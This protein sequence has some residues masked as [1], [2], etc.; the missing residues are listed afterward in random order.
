MST[1]TVYL[2][3]GANRGIGYGLVASLAARPNTI[4]FA[5]ARDPAAQSL[6]ELAAKHSN[7]HPVKLTSGDK[8]DNEAAVAEIQKTAGQLDV[9]IANAGIANYYGPLATTP[10]SEYR[11]HWEVNTLGPVVLF[12]ATHTLLLASPSGTPTFALISTGAASISAYYH[13]QA[14]PYGSSKAAANFLVKAL[15]AENPTLIALAIHPGWV[16]TDMGNVGAGF[17]G[18]PQA[19]VTTEDSVKGILSR[20]DG[21]TREKTGG[22]FWNWK[23][24]SNGKPWDI[25]TEEIPW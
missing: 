5:G 4:V 25:P 16:A 24:E 21:A 15:D 1:V 11:E 13:M 17:A 10:L 23:A 8:A 22:R 20:I 2:I 19:P 9:V 12:Q 3:S 7:V 14:G 6:K 18:L